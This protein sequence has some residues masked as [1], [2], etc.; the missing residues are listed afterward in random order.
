MHATGGIA[1]G[2]DAVPAPELDAVFLCE[3][4]D[5]V[6]FF[7]A[8]GGHPGVDVW[9]V[10]PTG[11]TIE[12]APDGWA[13]TRE[14]VPPE[15]VRLTQSDRSAAVRTLSTV[16]LVFRSERLSVEEMTRLAGIGPDDAGLTD[17]ADGDDRGPP[18]AYWVIEGSDRYA[19]VDDQVGEVLA[20]VARSETGLC[21]LAAASDAAVFAAYEHHP[22]AAPVNAELDPA[23]LA[24]LARLGASVH[25]I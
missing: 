18:H 16:A 12:P 7:V 5:D 14:P 9:E 15:R 13:L 11:L 17:G 1:A 25:K 2:A 19:T 10:D 22:H 4:L 24:L 20:R 21:A 6:E 8:F 23:A 3:T